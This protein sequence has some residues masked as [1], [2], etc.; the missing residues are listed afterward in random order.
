MY[1]GKV[2]KKF[3]LWLVV[4]AVVGIML[5][6]LIYGVFD[7]H[8]TKPFPIDPE[9]AILIASA[10]LT[11]SFRVLLIQLPLTATLMLLAWL[12]WSLFMGNGEQASLDRPQP[13]PAVS[14]PL[15]ALSLR[16]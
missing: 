16:I 9:S 1:N 6:A 15:I 12:L 14:P 4:G 11:L 13:E 7:F 8:D 2:S 5:F 3:I 10:L